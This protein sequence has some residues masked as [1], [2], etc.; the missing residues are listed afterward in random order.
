MADARAPEPDRPPRR[1]LRWRLA[2]ATFVLGLVVGAVVVGLASDGSVQFAAGSTAA[3]ATGTPPAGPGAPPSGGAS[4][5]VVVDA[6]CLRALN[7][8]QDMY[9]AVDGLGRAI[10]D[11]N[12]ARLDEI[13]RQ[14]Q[15]IQG[16]LRDSI[17][18]C[19]VITGVQ[20][21]GAA[22]GSPSP[23]ATGAAPTS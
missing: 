9:G 7:A 1:A 8:A 6:A 10:A 13:V 17:G 3:P 12:V 5:R 23:L 19:H 16:R 4:G 21:G 15:P 18:S 22:T 2:A 14:L 11:F 20:Q